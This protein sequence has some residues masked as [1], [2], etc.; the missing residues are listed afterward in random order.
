ME[1]LGIGWDILKE[2]N[3]RLIYCSITG[4][5]KD[6]PYSRRPSYDSVVSA[7]SGFFSQIMPADRP[8]VLGPA[9]SDAIT[10]LYAAYGVL[11][12][13][14]QR[15]QTGRG[16]RVDV[17]MIEAMV[18]FMRQSLV[19]SFERK[20]SPDPLERP[21]A[22]GTFAFQCGD[23]KLI[24]IH[25]S[26]PVKFWEAFVGVIGRS[27]LLQD[28]R[29]L[30]RADR[31]KHFRELTELLRPVFRQH[32]RKDW[33]NRLEEG[34]VPFAPINNLKDVEEDP[35]VRHMGT[36]TSYT[37]PTHGE[38]GA[39]KR[40][41]RFDGHRPDEVS[42]P[43]LLGQHTDQVLAEYGIAAKERAALR[44]TGTVA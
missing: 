41:V 35:Q 15:G 13:L 32:S 28:P 34:D 25:L 12:A 5:G 23:G 19:F 43:P 40:A 20:D 36:L 18:S 2:G 24:A 38:M 7:L 16:C 33:M 11:G 26:T 37:H 10:G 42:P 3:D 31:I 1:R 14:H 39:V 44:G 21:A 8:Q 27:E 17:A 4:F 22:S 6:G 29:F 30:T 9:V